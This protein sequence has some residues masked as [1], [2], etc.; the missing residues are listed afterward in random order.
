MVVIHRLFMFESIL[1]FIYNLENLTIINA[2]SHGRNDFLPYAL[3]EIKYNL[4]SLVTMRLHQDCAQSEAQVRARLFI[5][6][7]QLPRHTTH[8]S[9]RHWYYPRGKAKTNMAWHPWRLNLFLQMWE[10]DRCEIRAQRTTRL[11][12]RTQ[13]L[14]IESSTL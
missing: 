14:V 10:L 4:R 3:L 6:D 12:N 11:L 13:Y 8:L 7:Q 2:V 9:I 1:T 5:I